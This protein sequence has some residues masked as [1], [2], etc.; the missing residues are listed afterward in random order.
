MI[1]D[2]VRKIQEI[3]FV[4]NINK[5]RKVCPSNH[6]YG[7]GKGISHV[8]QSRLVSLSRGCRAISV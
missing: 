7:N 5:Q 8:A 6:L 1:G 2:L 4:R 3:S